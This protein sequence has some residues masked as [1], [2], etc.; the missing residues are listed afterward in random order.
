[1]MPLLS[2]TPIGVGGASRIVGDEEQSSYLRVLFR[3]TRASE[4][5][6]L[7]AQRPTVENRTELACSALVSSL[8]GS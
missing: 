8:M 5:A 1:M 7:Y 2:L 6:C 3:R 4:N